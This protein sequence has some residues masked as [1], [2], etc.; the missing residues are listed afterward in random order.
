MAIGLLEVNIFVAYYFLISENDNSSASRF[1]VIN[2]NCSHFGV[3]GIKVNFFT[4]FK[5]YF[6]F[7]IITIDSYIDFNSTPYISKYNT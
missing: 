4:F 2:V 7:Y 3:C 6:F 1:I 5:F